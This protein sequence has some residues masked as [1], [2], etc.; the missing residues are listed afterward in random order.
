MSKTREEFEAAVAELRT[1]S[2]GKVTEQVL[3]ANAVH[4]PLMMASF[5]RSCSYDDAA[6]VGA[7][8]AKAAAAVRGYL[9]CHTCAGRMDFSVQFTREL[10]AQDE[11]ALVAEALS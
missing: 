2:W 8:M 5:E 3:D 6:L 4:V 9:T 11:A 1:N 10:D 7:A